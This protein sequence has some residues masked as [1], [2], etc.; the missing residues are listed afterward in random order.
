M[1]DLYNIARMSEQSDR[2]TKARK[3]AGFK[4]AKEAVRHYIHLA[5]EAGEK[6]EWVEPTYS[7]NESGTA[8]FSMKRAILY[9]EAFG[10]SPLWLHQGTG[11]MLD[12][13]SQYRDHDADHSAISESANTRTSVQ[14]IPLHKVRITHRLPTLGKVEAGAWRE[15]Q[16]EAEGEDTEYVECELPEYKGVKAFCN[17]VVGTSM[18]KLVDDGGKIIWVHVDD[19]IGGLQ[20]NDYVVA[21]R[22]N[23]VPGQFE[24]TVKQL[25]VRE[26]GVHE[27]RP[28]STDPKWQAAYEIPARNELAQEG[29]EICGLVVETRPPKLKRSGVPIKAREEA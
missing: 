21:H 24:T 7:A 22:P 16:E 29:I 20:Q 9:A 14:K 4:T 1:F 25:F 27:L 28:C 15:M 11:D 23:G 18:N 10:V 5:K 19:A 12:G 3:H 2:L 17:W 6:S 13:V 8:T 26:D